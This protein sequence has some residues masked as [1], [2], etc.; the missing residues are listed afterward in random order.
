M[1]AGVFA[2]AAQRRDELPDRPVFPATSLALEGADAAPAQ[3]LAEILS[4]LEA[5]YDAWR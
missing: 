5:A 4:R 3:L 2:R 1:A